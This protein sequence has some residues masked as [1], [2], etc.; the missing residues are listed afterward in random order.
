[1]N[2]SFENLREEWSKDATIDDSELDTESLRVPRLIAKWVDHLAV[3]RLTMKKKETELK[4]LRYL[5]WRWYLGKMDQEE[6]EQL[7]WDQNDE[8]IMRKE[9]DLV[10]EADKEL[11]ELQGKVDYA[12]ER[13]RFV[14]S[15]VKELN[16]RNW[17]IRNAIEW[18]KF[19]QGID[20]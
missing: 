11:L 1:M 15:C 6:L 19:T 3:L 4:R 12:R 10:L 18:R 20:I 7:G 9:V 2:L 16:A 13:V 5:K 17:T 8:K 14:E